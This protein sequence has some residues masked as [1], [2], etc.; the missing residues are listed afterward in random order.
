MNRINIKLE[1][2]LHR[3]LKLYT[4]EQSTTIQALIVKLIRQTVLPVKG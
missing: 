3:R 4:F 1:P 2:E